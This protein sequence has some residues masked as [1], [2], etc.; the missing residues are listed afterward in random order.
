MANV[1]NSRANSRLKTTVRDMLLSLAVIAVPIAV[2][3]A[4]EPSKP[5]DPVHVID[6][7]SFQT[8]LSAARQAEPFTVLAPSGLPADWR[9]TSAYYQPPGA[10]AGDWHVG[11]LTPSGGYAALEQVT[12]PLA[13]FLTDQHSD[14]SPNTAAQIT[15]ATPGVWQRYTG[16]TPA[17]LRTIMYYN[18]SKSTVI[19]A[20]SASLTELEQLA[21][22]LH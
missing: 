15:G 11:Y 21:T 14:A 8:T 19:V 7:A 10:T 17:G 1:V 13:A 12:E 22:A 20:G 18:D 3:L 9:L 6:A 16:T 2:V 5:G 4:I